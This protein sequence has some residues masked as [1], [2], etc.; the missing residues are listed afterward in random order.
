LGIFGLC[1]LVSPL[2]IRRLLGFFD[3]ALVARPFYSRLFLD[4]CL[5]LA[6][7]LLLLVGSGG[8]IFELLGL[9]SALCFH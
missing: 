6:L 9:G 1:S 3:Q 8:L 2:L 5:F 7:G 4:V